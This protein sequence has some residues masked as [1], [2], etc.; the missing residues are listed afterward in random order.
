[1][2]YLFVTLVI[3]V[4]VLFLYIRIQKINSKIDIDVKIKRIN[5]K[6]F[7]SK[8]GR[9]DSSIKADVVVQIRNRNDFPIRI[10][11]LKIKLFKNNRLVGQSLNIPENKYRVKVPANGYVNFVH[12][13]EMFLIDEFFNIFK[14]AIGLD[15]KIRFKLF[16]V[17]VSHS[18]TLKLDK[19]D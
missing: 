10:S 1:M 3:L 19:D 4:I 15:Y 17:P 16:S 2:R 14:G 12:F 8:I 6:D 18:D 13:G 9:G 5:L 11:N 7:I